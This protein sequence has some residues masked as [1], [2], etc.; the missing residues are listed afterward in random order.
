M[1]NLHLPEKPSPF[2]APP[3]LINER[4][5][6]AYET[7][8]EIAGTRFAPA[9]SE[10]VPSRFKSVMSDLFYRGDRRWS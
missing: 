9:R 1:K 4:L 10:I 2:K 8:R 6:R 3:E 7:W 5:I